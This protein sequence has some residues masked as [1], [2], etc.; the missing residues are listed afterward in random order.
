MLTHFLEA[1]CL[2][3]D[4]EKGESGSECINPYQARARL[5]ASGWRWASFLVRASWFPLAPQSGEDGRCMPELVQVRSHQIEPHQTT[6]KC[7]GLPSPKECSRKSRRPDCTPVL[8][9]VHESATERL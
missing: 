3:L 6:P 5:G 9:R 7:T 4:E 2:S 1:P 8:L